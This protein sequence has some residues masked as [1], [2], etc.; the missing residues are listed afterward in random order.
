MK[1]NLQ[2]AVACIMAVMM[3]L[4]MSDWKGFAI[5]ANAAEQV[6][7]YYYNYNSNVGKPLS[8]TISVSVTKDDGATVT[9]TY[10]MTAGAPE[11]AAAAANWYK[12]DVPVDNPGA[13]STR[14]TG[15]GSG[16][17]VVKTNN[18]GADGF[19]IV[20]AAGS[21]YTDPAAAEGESGTE[22][23]VQPETEGETP[24]ESESESES[25]SGSESENESEADNSGENP[26][27]PP[28]ANTLRA[29]YYAGTADDGIADAFKTGW[30]NVYAKVF[31]Y[32]AGASDP[33]TAFTAEA[34]AADADRPGWFYIDTGLDATDPAYENGIYIQFM[35]SESA[36]S[37]EG[38]RGDGDITAAYQFLNNNR[39]YTTSQMNMYKSPE[40][41]IASL[42][43]GNGNT[44]E[45]DPILDNEVRVWFCH[46]EGWAGYHVLAS[47]AEG[48]ANPNDVNEI[49]Y[50][51]YA[52]G[53]AV[54]LG[55]IDDS[56]YNWYYA[57]VPAD[58]NY[59]YFDEDMTFGNG[60]NISEKYDISGRTS[61]EI[62]C[63]VNSAIIPNGWSTSTA[64]I[65]K[66]Y[67]LVNYPAS[68]QI[69]M[70][71]TIL[72]YNADNLFFE[73]DIKALR[74][75]TLV[76]GNKGGGYGMSDMG[77][78]DT[79][80]DWPRI[81][82]EETRPGS[83]PHIDRNG[84]EYVT[85]V[86]E[87]VLVNG[88]PV[89]TERAVTYVAKVVQK[90][91]QYYRTSGNTGQQAN[92]TALFEQIYSILQANG[93]LDT[94]VDSAAY[95]ASRQKYTEQVNIASYNMLEDTALTCMDYAYYVMNNL[96]N[97]NSLYNK[98]YGMYSYL[99]L[100]KTA[101][102]VYGFYANYQTLKP[103]AAN[104]R[105]N[106]P[107]H[108]EPSLTKGQG[109][110]YNDLSG[111]EIKQ[112][113]DYAWQNE[114]YAGFFPYSPQYL[115]AA[116]GAPVDTETGKDTDSG[117]NNYYYYTYEG[118]NQAVEYIPYND[119]DSDI[120]NYNYA[121][122]LNGKFRFNYEEDLYFTFTGDDDVVLYI[123][124]IKVLDLSGAHQAAS[125]T[126]YLSDLVDNGTIAM[127][128]GAYYDLD[129][130]YMERHTDWSNMRIE[131][132]IDV[133][134]VSGQVQKHCYTAESY[135][136]GAQI[137]I[138][139]GS[140]V[141]PKTPV[142]YE[143]ELNAGASDG[144]ESLGFHDPALGIDITSAAIELG[145]YVDENGV[146]QERIPQD[147]KITI[148]NTVYTNLDEA[149][150]QELLRIGIQAGERILISGIKYVVNTGTDGPVSAT[151]KGN[152]DKR[153]VSSTANHIVRVNAP[154]ISV[155]K[156]AANPEGTNLPNN[157]VLQSG[158]I[159]DY[160]ITLK[161]SGNTPVFNAGIVD[162]E[163]GVAFKVEQGIVTAKKNGYTEYT[164]LTF[165]VKG[166]GVT[167]GIYK[168]NNQAELELLIQ[169]LS[170]I[171]YP[172]GATLAV[173]GIKYPIVDTF[174]SEAVGTAD[175][176]NNY[177][178]S[179]EKSGF[180]GYSKDYALYVKSLKTDSPIAEP[181]LEDYL[182]Y[183][184][185]VNTSAHEA[186]K[187][188]YESFVKDVANAG[189]SWVT[190]V[191]VPSVA[192]AGFDTNG[193]LEDNAKLTLHAKFSAYNYY[194][195]AGQPLEITLQNG[196]REV[197]LQ[198]AGTW[199]DSTAAQTADA[200]TA[201]LTKGSHTV[202]IYNPVDSENTN[203][204]EVYSVTLTNTQNPDV[205]YVLTNDNGVKGDGTVNDGIS[206]DGVKFYGLQNRQD[207]ATYSVDIAEEGEYQVEVAYINADKETKTARVAFD[208]VPGNYV[209]LSDDGKTTAAVKDGG[210]VNEEG[211]TVYEIGSA[212][213]EVDNTDSYP[214]I[215]YTH[216]AGQYGIQNLNLVTKKNVNTGVVPDT[217]TVTT[218]AV[219]DDVYVLDYGLKVDLTDTAYGNGLFQND[220][221]SG[222]KGKELVD[223]IGVKN[224]PDAADR[225]V[226][227]YQYDKS[228]FGYQSATAESDAA[229]GI[230]YTSAY[231]RMGTLGADTVVTYELNKF[232][233]GIDR[234]AYAVQVG[235]ADTISDHT[236]VRDKT[237]ATPVME[238]NI[239]IMPASVVYYEDNFSGIITNGEVTD[240]RVAD[241]EREV[242][243]ETQ[244]QSI[245]TAGTDA[246]LAENQ[247]A[248]GRTFARAYTIGVYKAPAPE[249][250]CLKLT[251]YVT[252]EGTKVYDG[253]IFK[254]LKADTTYKFKFAID[255]NS[256]RLLAIGAG[257]PVTG[258][259]VLGDD[260]KPVF[261]QVFRVTT[262]MRN[263]IVEVPIKIPETAKDCALVLYMGSLFG[264]EYQD[265][266]WTAAS[267]YIDDLSVAEV[268]E[269]ER[270][271]TNSLT[272]QYGY[273]KAYCKD[274]EYSHN[275]Y[276]VLSDA[277]KIAFTF[278][279][280]G[281]DI[282]TRTANA[283]LKVSV[284]RAREVDL[285]EYTY[286]ASDGTIK[287]LIVVAAKNG[288]NPEPVKTAFVNA[289][290]ENG[291]I[292]QIPLISVDLDY[293]NEGYVVIIQRVG[294]SQELHI[295]GIRI[296]NPLG[297]GRTDE[298]NNAYNTAGENL[299]QFREVRNMI[300]GEEYVYDP[301][302]PA[303]PAEAG[304]NPVAG[305]AEI[306][307]SGAE[308][309]IS[310]VTGSTVT[311]FYTY[312]IKSGEIAADREANPIDTAS[313]VQ[314]AMSG[315]NNELYLRGEN[316]VFVAALDGADAAVLQIGMKKAGGGNVTAEYR[317]VN[318][319]WTP[320]VTS[321][322][323]LETA[324]EMYYKIMYT[325]LWKPNGTRLLM[326]RAAYDEADSEQTGIIALT[327]IK[328]NIVT[329]TQ[330][331]AEHF[332]PGTVENKDTAAVNIL[333]NSAAGGRT[334]IAFSVP[335]DVT[336][337]TISTD[338][339]NVVTV[340]DNDSQQQ[341]IVNEEVLPADQV[342]VNARS[343]SGLKTYVVKLQGYT[344]VSGNYTITTS[345]SEGSGHSYGAVD[346]S[347]Q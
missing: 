256:E 99:I 245:I 339:A 64:D 108:C 211:I 338:G 275:G 294:G 14:F 193:D 259:P 308:E 22:T 121:L 272:T 261:Y 257:D 292:S 182:E 214:V 236:A 172:E 60:G 33:V 276:S 162:N 61:N 209:I 291:D 161:N 65:V 101:P 326:I 145:T 157:S 260:G 12:A 295:D 16:D 92:K 334:N 56:G 95:N 273:D 274:G 155:T 167:D 315:P 179:A 131:S 216:E 41:A 71:I 51:D 10:E 19:V 222:I 347:I 114:G 231:G 163:L 58:T 42:K 80:A 265:A 192:D 98:D 200:G 321:G 24:S 344:S 44:V 17:A 223:F 11:G 293:E 127:A 31:Y 32:P 34:C 281:F 160:T 304:S 269:D 237:N 68:N 230:L 97:T 82:L 310:L 333:G 45:G 170:Q 219:T 337:F 317:N 77:I 73:Y 140:S 289:Y 323:Y 107:I 102:N 181:K 5:E 93:S 76:L 83:T 290:Y 217:V 26:I 152:T 27:L 213:I 297:M 267:L 207:S 346:F 336:E 136:T 185:D 306:T 226:P 7:I 153:D 63:A 122:K 225:V 240:N 239:T 322:Q 100:K 341:V 280:T 169:K 148:G 154:S 263:T 47:Y 197:E 143:Y 215:T 258:A 248:S 196:E 15:S 194:S 335:A 156:T 324:T 116:Y 117:D 253:N 173:S 278:K 48:G 340:R 329:F 327:N 149:Q 1:K 46:T 53:M 186:Y 184:E 320:L 50:G 147:L 343:S 302:A 23:P 110:I 113:G 75:M 188:V 81:D 106:Y 270:K 40:E 233:S 29:Y 312:S 36:K 262:A 138:P 299:A 38:F 146:E 30:E 66:A 319:E 43:A 74:N 243:W 195:Q 141:A 90:G 252:P 316:N 70:P 112:E 235:L 313:L 62:F 301:K 87:P 120:R 266:P 67:G 94:P 203:G 25:E 37:P 224:I 305:L 189:S 218:F 69:S 111:A 126:V 284:F 307:G 199:A 300:F 210:L 277:D 298:I 254:S 150:I 142:V 13:F 264:E 164:D 177:D 286:T 311:E 135:G 283:N 2:R 8:G 238:A 103:T 345:T 133:I 165:T 303:D 228:Q 88:Y 166:T 115:Q 242:A 176:I 227:L 178:L 130:F 35:E 246:I 220:R 205:K 201:E 96:Y 288:S 59:I 3:I 229:Y 21:V 208:Y 123:N 318:G 191:T 18:I 134:D 89:Y 20:T 206:T 128:T 241:G 79:T 119:D 104:I 84:V 168:V 255:T 285:K 105:Q 190:G 328:Y 159:A 198:T 251:D 325:D 331:K 57:D 183:P 151:M 6:T 174:P 9:G 39:I 132:N 118:L 244:W 4:T 187:A 314:Y 55:Y 287:N 49:T 202:T 234:Y 232:L 52:S 109:F 91:Y 330:V 342:K 212:V 125:Y 247:Q 85:G 271:Q 158:T 332:A 137:I 54:Q 282:L 144:L 221:I 28:K 129:F 309:R 249:S 296:Y 268:V 124:G 250:I 78:S 171:V 204:F 279:G 72:D 139:S 86:L 180:A 175:P